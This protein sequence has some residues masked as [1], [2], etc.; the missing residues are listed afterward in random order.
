MSALRWRTAVALASALLLAVTFAAFSTTATAAVP[1]PPGWT[2][3]WSDDFTGPAGSGVNIGNWQYTTGTSYPGGPPNFGTGEVE[4]MTSSTANVS[5]DGAGNL[6]ITPRRDGAGNWTSGRIETH[7]SDFQPSATGKLRV[8]ARIQMPNVTGAAA[9]GY[10][11]AFWMLG[12]PYRGNWWNWPMVGEIDILENVQGINNV[13]ATLHC[14]TSPGGPCGEKVGIGG[15]R[16]CSPVSCQAGFHTYTVEWDRSVSPHQLR[17]YLDGVQF[18]TVN[19]N[20]VPA[21]VWADATN[22]GFFIILNVAMGGEF[23]AAFGGGP[24][25]ATAPGIPMVVDYVAVW[26]AGSGGPP[27]SSPPPTSAPP[28]CG[29]LLSQGRPVTASSVESGNQA[30]AFAVDGNVGTRWSSAHNEPNWIRVDLG[31][32]R[33]ISRVRLNWEAAYGRTYEI[34]TSPDGS[35]WT[36]RYST[37]SGDGGIDDVAVS[38]TARYVRMNGINRATVYGFSLWE[39]EVFGPCTTPTPTPTATTAPPTGPPTPT[40]TATGAYPSWAAGVSYAVGQRVS[41]G[42]RNYQC[43]QA[44]TSQ[45]DWT[46]TA[47]PALWLEV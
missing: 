26:S 35:A 40:P 41:Y 5:L 2:H 6:R 9:R 21:N 36:T 28:T 33:Q 44:H 12:A 38:A 18:H 17:W 42:G 34:Q 13:W 11:P 27:P 23:P 43:R 19:A 22:H 16:V 32:S 1:V 46:P 3:V 20:Q 25:G 37:A 24:D 39:F 4:T 14:G 10:W 29:P 47:A 31:S 45:P 7:R 15:Q 30:A 8:E